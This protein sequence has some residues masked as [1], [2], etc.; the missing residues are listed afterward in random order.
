MHAAEYLWLETILGNDD[1]LCPGDVRGQLA[2]NHFITVTSG[3]ENLPALGKMALWQGAQ[4]I[5]FARA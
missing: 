2:G 3:Q 4:T 5:V 1:A